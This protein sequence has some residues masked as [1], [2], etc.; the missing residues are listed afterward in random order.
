MREVLQILPTLALKADLSVVQERTAGLEADVAVLKTD[1]A[2]LK[3]DV[4]VLKTD[5]AELK[6]DVAV[7]KTDVAELKADVAVLKTDMAQVKVEL[8][9]LRNDQLLLA[10]KEELRATRETLRREIRE[11]GERSR[12]HMD[13]LF[14]RQQDQFRLL[15]EGHVTLEA[16]E[17]SHF[18]EAARRL[19]LLE[20]DVSAL[21][22]AQPGLA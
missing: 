8:V 12:R 1:V 11:E 15:M 20:F 7:L 21:K 9:E 5:V 19:G 3:T 2:G 22:A 18:L 13:I 4:A 17:H 14:E 10:S 16:R 6:A